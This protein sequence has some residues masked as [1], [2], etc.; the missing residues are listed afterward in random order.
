MRKFGARG[1]IREVVVSF[2]KKLSENVSVN[3]RRQYF[4][5]EAHFGAADS[6]LDDSAPCRFGAGHF[7][8]VS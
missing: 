2:E 3:G 4:L 1:V 8:A 5:G 7:G 6:A